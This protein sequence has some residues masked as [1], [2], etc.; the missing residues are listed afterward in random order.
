MDKHCTST[1]YP[2][3]KNCKMRDFENC[4]FPE[5]PTSCPVVSEGLRQGCRVFSCPTETPEQFYGSSG[6]SSSQ[7]SAD[8]PG[9]ERP[10][11]E[12]TGGLSISWTAISVT[13]TVLFV[14][15][16]FVWNC[17]L[18]AVFRQ[19]VRACIGVLRDGAI[20]LA[21]ILWRC[22]SSG[23]RVSFGCL[24]VAWD[25]LRN[26]VGR[27]QAPAMDGQ[28][29]QIPQVVVVPAQGQGA[30]HGGP[31]QGVPQGQGGAQ[32]P[33]GGV[34][35]Q[36]NIHLNAGP[37]PGAAAVGPAVPNPPNHQPA[38]LILRQQNLPPLPVVPNQV[39]HWQNQGLVPPV[40]PPPR[41]VRGRAPLPPAQPQPGAQALPAQAG[42]LDSSLSDYD[43]QF[44]FFS[45]DP[46]KETFYHIA[47]DC[48]SSASDEE[49]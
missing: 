47:F 7:S 32:F 39:Q 23:L 26:M 1:W 40:V 21:L 24:R 6:Q 33:Q 37:N 44:S 5:W 3:L 15:G 12:D 28:G 46:F 14:L 25:H 30:A 27:Q 36:V 22:C 38:N 16:T 35:G 13:L 20:A 34:L 11:S 17:C 41:Q 10:D 43:E 42:N 49:I 18:T 8:M 29:V 48:D 45:P 31:Q 2:G 19:R 9:T 4:P